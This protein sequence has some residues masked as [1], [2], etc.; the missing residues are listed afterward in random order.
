MVSSI[1]IL[2]WLRVW[3]GAAFVLWLLANIIFTRIYFR[4][5]WRYRRYYRLPFL[6]S[7]LWLGF[8]GLAEAAFY[9]TAVE[10]FETDRGVLQSALRTLPVL[11]CTQAIAYIVFGILILKGGTNDGSKT[12][13]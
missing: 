12:G 5:Y 2:T 7:A 4:E 11:I 1:D 13:S 10:F 6:M 8:T 9:F 3:Y